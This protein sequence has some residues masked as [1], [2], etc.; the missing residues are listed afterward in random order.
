[1]IITIK[2]NLSMNLTASSEML[3]WRS[4]NEVFE[5]VSS[6]QEAYILV[7]ADWE[8]RDSPLIPINLRKFTKGAP[9]N[10]KSK[11]APICIWYVPGGPGQ[12]SKTLEVM[13]P[14]FLPGLPD[15]STLYAF[16]HRGLGKSTPLASETEKLLLEEFP[17]DKQLLPRILAGKQRKM[18]ITTPITRTLRVENVAR[19]LL[20]AVELVNKSGPI[21]SK[22]Y[23]VGISY[24]T[25]ISRRALQI[26]AEGTFEAVLL[27]GLAPVEQIELSNES[28]RLIQEICDLLPSCKMQLDRVAIPTSKDPSLPVRSLIPQIISSRMNSCTAYFMEIFATNGKSLCF[29]LHELMN[30]S[31]LQ[32]RA[33][34]KVASLR[35][36]FELI[37]C[38]DVEAFKQIFDEINTILTG[39]KRAV[40]QL[41]GAVIVASTEADPGHGNN[42]GG[43]LSSDELV[44]EVVSALERYDISQRSVDICYNKKHLTNG[45]ARSICPARL[46]DPCKF[47]QMTYERKV[48]LQRIFGVLPPVSLSDPLVVAPETRI[49]VLSGNFDFNTPTLMSRQIVDKHIRGKSVHYHESFGYGHSVFGSSDCDKEIL[50][51]FLFGR[52]NTDSCVQKWNRKNMQILNGFFEQ[53]LVDLAAYISQH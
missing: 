16:D 28:D 15:G 14:V 47:F 51:D 43:A 8:D 32:G 36:L 18:G 10:N 9:Q 11:S 41:Q 2:T 53:S 7:P 1:M 24:G 6:V 12:S 20:K 5:G 39:N 44:F 23:L 19:D 25:M 52:N 40:N 34:V 37:S 26:A 35:I 33:S 4:V 45:D 3:L 38:Q 22:N 21:G 46:F 30:A 50:S 31:L 27:D 17:K 48:A 42:P 13:L 49:L 29:A